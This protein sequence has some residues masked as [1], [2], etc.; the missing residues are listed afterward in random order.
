MDRKICTFLEDRIKRR[1]QVRKTVLTTT[2]L[3][4][5]GKTTKFLMKKRREKPYRDIVEEPSTELGDRLLREDFGHFS[6]LTSAI[7]MW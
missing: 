1:G 6:P 7:I 4:F 3:R 5:T 2:I